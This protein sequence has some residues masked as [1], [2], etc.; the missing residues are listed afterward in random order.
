MNPANQH[1][2]ELLILNATFDAGG[3]IPMDA[4]RAAIPASGHDLRKAIDVQRNLGN[5]RRDGCALELTS[6]ARAAIAAGRAHRPM[7][8][9]NFNPR[10][11][12]KT[13]A[14]V[15]QEVIRHANTPMGIVA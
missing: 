9:V 11:I 8:T 6:C 14:K 7:M 5:I 1:P 4:L 10:R 15:L 3:R 12:G 13:A 2:L